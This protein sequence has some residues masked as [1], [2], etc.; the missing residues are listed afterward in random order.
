MTRIA[1]ALYFLMAGLLAAPTVAEAQTSAPYREISTYLVG[2]GNSA[3]DEGDLSTARDLFE[4]AV[5]S[6]PQNIDAYL[7]LGKTHFEADIY[8]TSLKY[9]D[10]ALSIDPTS[11]S[12]LEGQTYVYL[13]GDSLKA[14][15]D[16]LTKLETICFSDGCAEVDRVTSAINDYVASFEVETDNS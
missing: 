12:A 2:E 9:Y 1:T 11:L 14:A 5:V 8:P 4:Q 10:I 15:R 3:L 16:N 7:G 13:A 6:D